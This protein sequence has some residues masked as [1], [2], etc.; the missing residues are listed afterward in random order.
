MRKY[1]PVFALLA[2]ALTA[3]GCGLFWES[4]VGEPIPL[5]VINTTGSD[6]VSIKLDGKLVATDLKNVS[7]ESPGV[8]QRIALK[9]GKHRVEALA[10]SGTVLEATDLK[11]GPKTRGFLFAPKHGPDACFAIVRNSPGVNAAAHEAGASCFA[12][13]LRNTVHA[14]A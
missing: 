12:S 4:L 3:A 14:S 13:G 8:A 10:A 7:E 2:L 11:V 9:Q 6:G 5:W 1:A